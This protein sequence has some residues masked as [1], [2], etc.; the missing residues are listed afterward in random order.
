MKALIAENDATLRALTG[1]LL[2][3]AGFD[4]TVQAKDGREAFALLKNESSDLI[5]S[6]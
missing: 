6:D 1:I 2:K 5:V 4:Q 3:D